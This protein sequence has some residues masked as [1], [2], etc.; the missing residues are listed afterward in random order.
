[1]RLHKQGTT[2]C[3]LTPFQ[4]H[5]YL[6]FN[7]S[8]GDDLSSPSAHVARIMPIAKWHS[9]FAHA[10]LNALTHLPDAVEGAAF[11]GP[12]KSLSSHCDVCARTKA[13]QIISRSS[14]K[15]ENPTE[16]F[17]RVSFDLI[18]MQPSSDQHRWIT[19]LECMT[20][21]FILTATHKL[22]SEAPDLILDFLSIIKTRYQA[23]VMFFRTDGETSLDQSFRTDLS[24]QG[25][26]FKTSA[27]RTPEQNGNSERAGGILILKARALRTSGNLPDTL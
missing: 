14:Y 7:K 21:K 10:G 11:S 3:T 1:M 19:H 4:G 25:I 8:L 9:I 20:S 13:H 27:P 26:I 16:P 12:T 17:S 24:A 18:H 23:T 22:K 5:F 6:E 15:E 2:L